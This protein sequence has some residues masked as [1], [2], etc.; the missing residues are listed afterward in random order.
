MNE[1]RG[2]RKTSLDEKLDG[3]FYSQSFK[4]ANV[5]KGFAEREDEADVIEH[6][7]NLFGG[8]FL[9]AMQKGILLRDIPKKT[10]VFYR[11]VKRLTF[12]LVPR[13]AEMC[14]EGF[15]ITKVI[16][17][18]VDFAIGNAEKETGGTGRAEDIK[19]INPIKTRADMKSIP[20]VYNGICNF[21]LK[22][23]SGR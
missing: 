4:P 18:T 14:N 17:V 7:G 23:R 12:F 3:K 2:I 6:T 10:K 13:N 16:I 15:G 20:N 9:D 21:T 5:M 19:V 22:S 11:V 8:S 1:N